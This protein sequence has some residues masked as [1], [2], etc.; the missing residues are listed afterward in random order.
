ML[1]ANK[2]Y[3]FPI[4]KERSR[5]HQPSVLIWRF[6]KVRQKFLSFFPFIV[7]V[8]FTSREG[9]SIYIGLKQRHCLCM[10]FSFYLLFP[11]MDSDLYTSK[12][13]NTLMGAYVTNLKMTD[14]GLRST[15]HLKNVSYLSFVHKN[16]TPYMQYIGK[17]TTN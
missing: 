6:L 5:Q 13:L 12:K 1:A 8:K 4:N 15:L 9:I 14:Y 3:F 7:N 10:F 16:F 11:F 17:V 2:I